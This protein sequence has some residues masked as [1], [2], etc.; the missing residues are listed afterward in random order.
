VAFGLLLF[1]QSEG[2]HSARGSCVVARPSKFTSEVRERM[3]IAIRAGNFVE[4]AARYAGISASTYYEWCA[5]G[6]RGEPGFA[7][8]VEAVDQALA[9]AEVRLVSRISKAAQEG[10]WRA[11]AW[12]LPRRFR[13]RWAQ[14]AP[15]EPKGLLSDLFDRVREQARARELDVRGRPKGDEGGGQQ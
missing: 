10:D 14:V 6:E 13:E 9:E 5:R 7:E 15:Q 3:L 4:V 8:F 11:A 1:V 12:K 2:R